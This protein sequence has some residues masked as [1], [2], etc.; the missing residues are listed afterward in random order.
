MFSTTGPR[1]GVCSFFVT[2][3]QNRSR[4]RRKVFVLIIM[5]HNVI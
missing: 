2:M 1:D 3:Y 4:Q 5:F